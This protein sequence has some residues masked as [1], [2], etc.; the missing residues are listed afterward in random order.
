[1]ND[2][3]LKAVRV[4]AGDDETG[5]RLDNFLM[6]RLKGVPRAHVYRLIRS[7]QVRVNSRR[8]QASYR[9]ILGDEVRVPPV[10]QPDAMN[11]P[12]PARLH[13]DWIFAR[14]VGFKRCGVVRPFG[15]SDHWPVWAEIE[16]LTTR[17]RRHEA[18]T[19]NDGR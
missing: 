13:T 17:S 7:G 10:R 14:G 1:M 2:A 12:P 19:M 4:T 18:E 5:R 16:M 3:T 9:L 6:A 15:V 11:A 8:V